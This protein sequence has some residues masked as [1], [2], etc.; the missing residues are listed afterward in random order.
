MS[1]EL[2]NQLMEQ[3][4]DFDTLFDGLDSNQARQIALAMMRAGQ[5][6]RTNVEAGRQARTPGA[7]GGTDDDGARYD[8]DA[9]NILAKAEKTGGVV[10]GAERD[11]FL[12]YRRQQ[13]DTARTTRQAEAQQGR[14][15]HRS[16]REVL[17]VER[18][19]INARSQAGYSNA[20]AQ[21]VR[22]IRAEL[23]SLGG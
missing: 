23:Q 4:D 13:Q 22:E 1:E 3:I 2:T 12:K 6:A 15:T 7:P 9:A 8:T 14:E 11:R 10:T 20:D 19:E 16:R 17:E 5:Q 18:Q 21:R